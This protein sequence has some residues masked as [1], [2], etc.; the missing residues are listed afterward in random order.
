MTPARRPFVV[1]KSDSSLRSSCAAAALVVF[2]SLNLLPAARSVAATPWPPPP[3]LPPPPE[4]GPALCPG[5]FLTE[6]Q[7]RAALDFTLAQARSAVDWRRQ[8][9]HWRRRIVEAAGLAPWPART[10]LRPIIR[11][12]R[13]FPGYTIEAV[14]F[15]SIPGYWVTGNLYRPSGNASAYRHP[16]ILT[17]HGHG[18]NPVDPDVYQEVGRFS[19]SVQ[20]RAGL[21]ARMGA[22]VLAI[23]GFAHGESRRM[24][25]VAAHKTTL[26]LPLQLW[27]NRRALDFLQ[28]LPDVDGRL[29]GVT[30]ESGG[31]TQTFLLAALD[32]RVS[33]AAPVV[34]VSAHFFG[35]CACESGRPIHRGPDHFLS[36]PVIAALAAPRPLL[37]VSVG[38]DWTKNTPEVE[39]P[40]LRS[41]Y[42]LLDAEPRVTNVHL[43]DEKHDYG[44]S[45]RAAVYRWMAER[46][47]L[48][49]RAARTV[50]GV[51]DEASIELLTAEELRVFPRGT[52]MPEGTL[53]SADR[54]EAAL[55]K[56]QRK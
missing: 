39:Y 18:P 37:L 7:G 33:A 27:N 6:A 45:K 13:E 55:A 22:V 49:P 24:V 25:P 4:A 54:I 20:K 19:E 35:G 46:L 29:L 56:A 43:P 40:F 17:T 21:F 36:N 52:A 51:W 53:T 11:P 23:D 9:E 2:L 44:P 41:I 5:A 1:A 47:G 32:E 8:A 10:P 28:S 42:R 26:T 3:D 14:A 34:M 50:E 15:E 30:G 16:A 31:G 38:G 12:V 48:D